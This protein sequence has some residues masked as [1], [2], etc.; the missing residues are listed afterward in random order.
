VGGLL[1]KSWEGDARKDREAIPGE[2]DEWKVRE[3]IIGTD[4]A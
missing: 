3:A 2:G 1:A 4:E